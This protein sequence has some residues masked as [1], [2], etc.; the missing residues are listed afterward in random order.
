MIRLE[1]LC[2]I[3]M[4]AVALFAAPA[5][6]QVD[7]GPLLDGKGSQ[8]RIEEAP[9]HPEAPT[10]TPV[11]RPVARDTGH[12]RSVP[13]HARR[14]ATPRLRRHVPRL[15]AGDEREYPAVPSGRPH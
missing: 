5:Q 9:P 12:V 14:S 15:D 3:A 10:P 4:S 2:C 1:R 11:P 6:A 7:W 8:P 13:T